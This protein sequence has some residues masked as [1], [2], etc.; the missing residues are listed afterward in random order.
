MSSS[1]SFLP[2]T[3]INSTLL[4]PLFS[5]LKSAKKHTLLRNASLLNPSKGPRRNSKVGFKNKAKTWKS[6]YLSFYFRK[7]FRLNLTISSAKFAESPSKNTTTTLRIGTMWGIWN[8]A[9]G[10]SSW[11]KSLS[12]R[13]SGWVWRMVK[14]RRNLQ[15]AN[16]KQR[17]W[18]RKRVLVEIWAK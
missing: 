18:D 14:R 6:K 10:T 5:S 4:T 16:K 3:M 15:L 17:G 8:S 1:K 2:T 13:K 11:R 7:S 12:R 9:R